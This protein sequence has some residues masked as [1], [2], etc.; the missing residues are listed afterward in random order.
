MP[1]PT[2]VDRLT[3]A[4]GTCEGM[5]LSAADVQELMVHILDAEDAVSEMLT[6]RETEATF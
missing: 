5:T 6:R 4:F 3:D 2:V 1:Q